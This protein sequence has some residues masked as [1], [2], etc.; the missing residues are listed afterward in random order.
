MVRAARL[1][2]VLVYLSCAQ[3]ALGRGQAEPSSARDAYTR[4]IELE[5]RGNQSGALALLWY[6]AGLTPRDADV[7]NRLGEALE[8]IGALDAAIDAFRRAVAERPAFRKA[9]NNL[10]LTLVKAGKGPEAIA[11]ARA[12]VAAAPDDPDRIFTLGLAE[13]EQDVA[14]AIATFR[15]VLQIEPKHTLARYNL[16]L[17]LKRADRLPEA[18]EALQRALEI[19]PRPEALYTLGVI[20]WQQGDTERAARALRDAVA[21]DARYADAHYTLGAV[22]AARNDWRG[23][24]DALRRAIALR[25]NLPGAHYSLARV[26]QQSGEAAAGAA[27]FEEAERLRKRAQ[28]EQEAGVWTAVGS[29]TLESGDL[30]GALDQ[31]RRATAVFDG[32][33]P[34]HFQIGLVLRR[35][36][37]SEAA[38]AA[39]HR[40]AQ[41]NPG[42]VAPTGPQ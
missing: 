1:A 7:Q 26:L 40:A 30:T 39:F 27:E 14:A 5:S 41:L 35:L 38:D 36:G 22:L 23:A 29:R 17:V 16:A 2:I 12:L 32:Y 28:A 8:R 19:E 3:A 18:I 11:R 33:A 21:A 20:Y 34:A 6:A 42:L 13:S 31:F 25:P 10:I 24:A 15:R 37:Q 4:A 9:D